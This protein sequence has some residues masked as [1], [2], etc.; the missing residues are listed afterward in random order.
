M[1]ARCFAR[2]NGVFLATVAPCEGGLCAAV[3]GIF[4]VVIFT[5]VL[6]CVFLGFRLVVPLF[7]LPKA[8]L[9]ALRTSDIL[10]IARS[11]LA[12]SRR[13]IPFLTLLLLRREWEEDAIRV[14]TARRA[15][16][17]FVSTVTLSLVAGLLLS[18]HSGTFS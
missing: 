2:P 1:L 3:F 11:M 8:L 14:R 7:L 9:D 5:V 13:E 12:L 17:L 16:V 6:L 18:T 4:V 15:L 10:V